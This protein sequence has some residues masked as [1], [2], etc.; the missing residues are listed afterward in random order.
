M[1]DY[2]R[3]IEEALARKARESERNRKKVQSEAG[4]MSS[5]KEAFSETGTASEPEMNSSGMGNLE[6]L[7]AEST[8]KSS[9]REPDSSRAFAE[10]VNDSLKRE[11]AASRPVK[12]ETEK[13][14]EAVPEELGQTAEKMGLASALKRE[15]PVEIPDSILNEA[16]PKKPV[17]FHRSDDEERTVI[18]RDPGS[19]VLAVL[20]T[21]FL[22]AAGIGASLFYTLYTFLPMANAVNNSSCAEVFEGDYIAGLNTLAEEENLNIAFTREVLVGGQAVRDI[23]GSLKAAYSGSSY[24]P[25]T[26]RIGGKIS[27]YAGAAGVGLTDGFTG[28]A[29]E[30][31]SSILAETTD[32][33]WVG[34]T[35]VL[36]TVLLLIAAAGTAASV[37]LLVFLGR[38]GTAGSLARF[39][40]AGAALL[41]E[42]LSVLVMVTGVFR[43]Y[44]AAYAYITV[45]SDKYM[46]G[47]IVACMGVGAF[48]M[49]LAACAAVLSTKE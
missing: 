1:S 41:V 11:M 34:Q 12:T 17:R 30:L 33:S 44:N 47:A 21:L 7:L 16:E 14:A 35:G 43:R 29:L 18:R 37:V 10:A 4:L 5:L 9:S 6:S 31:Y 48:F 38:R 13:K 25:D 28:K 3:Q 22:T 40:F 32:S 20:L 26:E 2:E 39:S 24:Q 36:R 23:K 19:F 15:T 42:L 46:M 8:R 45:L 49:V 27:A